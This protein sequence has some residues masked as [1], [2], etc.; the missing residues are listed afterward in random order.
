MTFPFAVFNHM[1]N[2]RRT[3]QWVDGQIQECRQS[4]RAIPLI[5]VSERRR[6]AP[7]AQSRSR[8]PVIGIQDALLLFTFSSVGLVFAGGGLFAFGFVAYAL[9]FR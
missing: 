6:P 1:A 7:A 3:Y 9:I 5:E 8:K 2:S 4:H